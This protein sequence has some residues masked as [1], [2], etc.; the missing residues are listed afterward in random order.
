MST[1]TQDNILFADAEARYED[2]EFVI[3]GVPFDGTS[4]H[5]KGSEYAPRAIRQESYNF[6][7]YMLGYNIDLVSPPIMY[8]SGDIPELKSLNQMLKSVELSTHGVLDDNKFPVIMGGE[9]SLT[10]AVIKAYTS[11]KHDEF[12]DL[13]VIILDAHMDFRTQYLNLENSHACTS[14]RVS[15]LVGVENIYP[16][17]IRSFSSEEK[18]DSEKFNLTYVTAFDIIKLGIEKKLQDLLGAF[19]SEAPI[20]LSLDMDVIDPAYAPGVGTPEPYG[21]TPMDIKKCIDALAPRLVGFDVVEVSPPF[22][23]GN[24]SNLA[25]MMIRTVVAA[26][27]A[28]S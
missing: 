22:D 28:K 18:A 20:Y 24:T 27:K 4:T 8:D 13:V 26:V 14:R 7:S 25:A 2:A 3:Y 21:L 17:G 5:R 12:S 1:E 11:G 19:N 9:H 16:A 15:D 10:A 23:N 6:E